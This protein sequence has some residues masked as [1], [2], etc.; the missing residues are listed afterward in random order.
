MRARQSVKTFIKF[1]TAITFN[2]VASSPSIRSIKSLIAIVVNTF[3]IFIF[4][5]V[6]KIMQIIYM[7]VY[8]TER[9]ENTPGRVD[10]GRVDSGADLT[11]GRVDPLPLR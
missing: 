9:S 3:L 11:S 2:Q 5:L 10:S 4:D 7:Y 6:R 8:V 1:K